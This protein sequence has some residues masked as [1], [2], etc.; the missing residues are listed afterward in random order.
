IPVNLLY[1]GRKLMLSASIPFQDWDVR[2]AGGG[3]TVT[4]N[5]L[6]DPEIKA[7][8]QIWKNYEGTHAVALHVGGRFPGDNYHQ[9][10]VTMTGKS[11]VGVRVGPANSTRGAW[12]EFGGAY[13][14]QLSDRWTSHLN[15]ALANDSEDSIARYI[16]RGMLDYRVNHHLSLMAELNGQTWE[17]DNGP[18]GPN[19]DVTLGCAVFNADWQGY[20]GFPIAVSHDWGY[21]HDFGVTLG[22]NTRW[23]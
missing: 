5:G 11:R 17:M 19:V 21:G 20:L 1:T 8:Y 22:L 23:D 4:L 3:P 10:L 6:H 9:P 14:G 2:A 16:Y 13:T 18:D 7:G 15:L 12:T